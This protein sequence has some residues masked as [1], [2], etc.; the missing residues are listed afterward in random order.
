MLT[1]RDI[2]KAFGRKEVLRGVSFEVQTGEIVALLGESGS[3]KS[4]LLSIIAGL[5]TADRGQVLWDGADVGNMPIHQRGFGLMFQ[6]YALFPHRDVYGNV[7][8]GLQMAGTQADETRQRVQQALAMVE[9]DG[10]DDRDVAQLSGGEQQ[11]VAL[12]RALAP[13][14]RLLMLDEPLG[15][16]D[17][18]LRGQLVA[19]LRSQ[20]KAA[21]QTSLYVTHDQEEAFAIADRIVILKDGR[22][23][24]IGKPRE[25]YIRPAS[26]Y[27][28]RFLGFENIFR[29]GALDVAGLPTEGEFLL[30]PDAL[31]V[32]D[33]G[34]SV[35]EGKL[36][37]VEFRGLLQRA[38][39][40]TQSGA[41]LAMDLS[42]KDALPETG[43]RVKL[44]FDPKEAIQVFET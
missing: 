1:I 27:V 8:F 44:S 38:V 10:F 43:Q 7:A 37:S 39:V 17:K 23:E 29:G 12:A 15:S 42:A 14:P 40:R 5:E 4:T 25:L 41:V 24:Q 16:L 22:V 2:H 36:I 34:P 28:A 26:A 35:L 18:N 6:D 33:N 32:G 30:R 3:G 21:N 19:S 11:R 20:L 13:E 31:T 9:L